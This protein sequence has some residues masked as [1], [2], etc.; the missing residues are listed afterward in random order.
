MTTSV[1]LD[2]TAI[3]LLPPFVNLPASQIIV[4][5][6]QAQCEALCQP[7]FTAPF[8]GFDTESKPTFKIGEVSTGPHL[9][10][11]ATEQCAY[12]FQVN[13]ETLHFLAPILSNPLQLKV[14]FGLKND[15]IIFHRKNIELDGI[16]ELSKQFSSFGFK[17][18]MGIQKAVALLFGQYLAKSKHLSTSNWAAKS[19]NPQQINYAA[20]D[21]YAALLIFQD[22]KQRQL[23]HFHQ[24]N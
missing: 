13:E 17:Q 11:L 19:L 12:L 24:T 21:A 1:N 6:T 4:L 2:K 18:Q 8:L 20:A 3:R 16:I 5:Q 23:I 7:L 9:I 15:R 22:L 14:G 10:Q